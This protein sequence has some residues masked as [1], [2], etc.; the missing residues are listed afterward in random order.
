MAGAIMFITSLLLPKSPCFVFC[1]SLCFF[2]IFVLILKL[3]FGLLRKQVN[4]KS[5]ELLVV[6]VVV[7][8]V[9]VIVR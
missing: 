6:V 5:I 9:V 2:S 3:A 4:K 1:L 7:V 8:V